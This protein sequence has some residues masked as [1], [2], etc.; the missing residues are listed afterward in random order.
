MLPKRVGLCF[1][2]QYSLTYFRSISEDTHVSNMSRALLITGATGKQGGAV[3]N[4]LLAQQPSDFLLLAATQNAQSASAKRL[5]AKSNKIKLV[6]GDLDA[7]P[8]LF[9][10]AKAA[11]GSVP[12]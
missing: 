10:S 5:A 12:L 1:F 7:T 11:A 8:A 9:T 4:A 3:I 6:Q 2:D